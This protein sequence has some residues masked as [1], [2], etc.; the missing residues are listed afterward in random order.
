MY[1]VFDATKDERFHS[2]KVDASCDTLVGT[3]GVLTLA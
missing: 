1:Y 3:E 2:V